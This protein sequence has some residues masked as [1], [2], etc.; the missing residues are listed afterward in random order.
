MPTDSPGA[1]FAYDLT[2]D[3]VRRRAAV[4]EA[5]G[6]DWD[7]VH[8][9]AEEERAYALLYSGLDAEQRRHYDEL[10]KAGVLPHR[11]VDRAAD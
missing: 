8:A 2:L 3:E 4:L 9:L 10:V 5:I 11:A 1:E 6:D 7:P